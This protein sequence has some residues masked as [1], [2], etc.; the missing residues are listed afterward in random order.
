MSIGPVET[1]AR[2]VLQSELYHSD[3][4][5]R[6]AVDAVL[7]QPIYD[8]GPD[9]TEELKAARKTMRNCQGAVETNQVGD[10]N[11]RGQLKRGIRRID[12]VLNEMEL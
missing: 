5:V 4:D 12:E 10:K 3:M 11:V 8:A 9:L 2:Y 6:D 1:L 7:G